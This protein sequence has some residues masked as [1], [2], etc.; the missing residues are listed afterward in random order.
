MEEKEI[1]E[2]SLNL[3]ETTDVMYLSTI[4]SDGFPYTRIMSNLRNKKE[5]PGL[6]E[7]FEPHKEDFLVYMVTSS[8]SE[9]MKQIRA[10]P[11]VSVYL[12][13]NSSIPSEFQCLMLSGETK[14]V[15]DKKLKKQLWQD[16]WEM[17]WPGGAD[18]PEYTVLMLMPAFARGGYQQAPF[19]FK[20]K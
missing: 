20:L 15:E 18:D 19:E 5:Y 17:F 12:S 6:V 16:G 13:F 10:N 3:M 14:E 9:K 4:G 11:K 1:K 7:I 2:A 8:S